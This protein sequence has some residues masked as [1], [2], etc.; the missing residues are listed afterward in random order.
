MHR[1]VHAIIGILDCSEHPLASGGLGAGLASFHDHL[2]ELPQTFATKVF[3]FEP[4]G[5]QMDEARAIKEADGLVLVP[6]TGDVSLYLSAIMADFAAEVLR[7]FSNMV[8]PAEEVPANGGERR[9]R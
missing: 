5:R 1:R 8:S 3:G 4:S 2:N 6:T 9:A 7:E